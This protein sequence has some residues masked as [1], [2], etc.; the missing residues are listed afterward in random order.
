MSNVFIKYG[1]KTIQEEQWRACSDW[2]PRQMMG[3][4][5][6]YNA[7][8]CLLAT[9]MTLATNE[10]NLSKLCVTDLPSCLQYDISADVDEEILFRQ[11]PQSPFYVLF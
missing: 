8:V 7:N 1:V 11:P 5:A 6:G 2:Q 3:P 10:W 9:S 4:T